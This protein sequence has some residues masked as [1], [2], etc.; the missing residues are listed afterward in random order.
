MQVAIINTLHQ[1]CYAREWRRVRRGG[2]SPGRCS[3]LFPLG[4]C[5]VRS[6]NTR[7][8]LQSNIKLHH[9]NPDLQSFRRPDRNPASVSLWCPGWASMTTQWLSSRV[10]LC[11]IIHREHFLSPSALCKC[12]LVQTLLSLT[13]PWHVS[14]WQ[15]GFECEKT[16][17]D[18]RV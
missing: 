6:R 1:R 18:S 10:S 15:L 2:Q 14:L 4:Y 9:S 13:F 5:S 11:F 8:M 17:T 3:I 12:S 7:C 16:P